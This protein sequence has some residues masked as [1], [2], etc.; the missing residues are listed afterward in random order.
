M[1]TTRAGFRLLLLVLVAC[2]TEEPGTAPS[3]VPVPAA[4][5]SAAF[6][7]HSDRISTARGLLAVTVLER[8]SVLLG[9]DG[10]AIYVDPTSTAVDDAALPKADVIFVTHDHYDHCDPV[11]LAR[12]EKPGTVVVAP[13]AVAAR[14][15]VDVVLRNGEARDVAGIGV[16]AVPMYNVQRGPGPGLLYH[17]PGRGNGYV[18]DLAGT[19]VYFSGDTECTAEMKALEG[20]DIAFVSVSM[21][22]T[23]A[24]DEASACLAAMHPRVA[25]P[26][27]ETRPVPELGAA[28]AGSG[29]DVRERQLAPPD[30]VVRRLFGPARR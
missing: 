30:G 3:A 15:R 13:P 29:I 6:T 9:W 19:H 16:L 28:L 26:Y 4:P 11:A 1:T 24:P 18:L 2:S 25:F 21:P 5:A 20:L 10:K 17:P 27:H 23:M 14:S 12:L 22:T 7:P 8:A